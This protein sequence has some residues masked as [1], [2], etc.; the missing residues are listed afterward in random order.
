MKK[1]QKYQLRNKNEDK[2]GKPNKYKVSVKAHANLFPKKCVPLYLEEIKF[3]VLR[4][5]WKVTKLYKHFYFDQE[6]CKKNFIL[7]NQKARQE[8]PD[9]VESGFCKLLNNSNFGYD[10]RNNL[11]NLTFQPIRDELN[12]LN[13]IKK[14]P[15]NLYN[16]SIKKFITSQVIEDDIK[17]RYNN[18]MQKIKPDDKFYTS[19]VKNIEF[20]KLI[21][22]EAL[23]SYKAK[24]TKNHRKRGLE[25]Y[26]NVI[27]KAQSD[28]KIKNVIDFSDQDVASVKAVA[29]KK[30]DK[31]KITT[32]F[33]KGKMLMFSKISLKSF[34]YDIIDIFCFPDTVITDIYKKNDIL[35]V[36]VYLILTDTDSCSLQF[37]FINELSCNISEDR[38][39]DIIFEI[40]ILKLADRLDTSHEFFE[41]FSCRDLSTKK[42]VGLYE[43][44][45]IDNPNVV[46]IAVNPKEYLEIFR[47]KDLNKKHKGIKKSTPGM[48][49]ESFSTRIMDTKEYTF[50]QKKSHSLKQSRFKLSKTKMHFKEELK[51]QFAGLNDKRYYLPDGVTSLPYGHFLLT[52]LDNK[53]NQKN[54]QNV[55]LKIK[56]DLI[57]QESNLI[58]KCERIL[59]LRSILNQIPT[60]YKLDSLKRPAIQQLTRTTKDY[61]LSG[62]W[63]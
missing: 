62:L 38:A 22:T 50:A 45:S 39:K 53:K 16:P 47:S 5:G 13:F 59:V 43:V 1:I 20:R 26:F 9:K 11:D 44:E 42:K 37:T 54:I 34:V 30:K 57:R 3:A 31:V 61:V 29:V 49:F 52:E 60:Y 23:E 28:S 24:E 19:K 12:E 46:T 58:K 15:S 21:E 56:D 18:D 35:K 36:F 48:N 4:C 51:V 33:M 14:Y 17:E 27:E 7:M 2:N 6:R 10:C 40:L 63:Q 25:S 32:R 55:L 8:A 41:R